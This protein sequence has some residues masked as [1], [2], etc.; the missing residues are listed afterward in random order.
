LAIPPDGSNDITSGDLN[1]EGYENLHA[2]TLI[3]TDPQPAVIDG[4]LLDRVLRVEPEAIVHLENIVVRGGLLSWTGTNDFHDGAGILNYGR[5]YLTKVVVENNEASCGQETCTF[6]ISGGGIFNVG[7]MIIVDSMIRNNESVGASAI[8][9]SGESIGIVIKNS[10]IYDNHATEAFTIDN[11]AYLH[12]RNSTLSGNTALIDYVSGIANKGSFVLESSTV[13]NIGRSSSIYNDASGK[14]QIKDS[15]LQ[16]DGAP[17]SGN[18]ENNGAW[19]SDGYNIYSDDSCPS[20][21]TGDLGNTDAQLGPLGDWGGPTL[22]KPLQAGSPARDHRPGVC[23]TIPEGPTLP[24]M[25]LTEDQRHYARSD[26]SC[27]TGAFEVLKVYLPLI[28]K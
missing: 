3:G 24:P 22:T 6:Y 27:D 16:N 9:N 11:Y 21:G 20:T 15:I 4:K 8:Y 26:G 12:I 5:T 1:F 19:L 17:G 13:A 14:V 25:Q 28:I 7:Q 18:C 10:T 2:I 23:L